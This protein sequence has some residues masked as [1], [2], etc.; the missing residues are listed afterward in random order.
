MHPLRA[1]IAELEQE[2]EAKSAER[3][4]ALI[5]AVV[6]D[7]MTYRAAGE[8]FGISAQRV[9]QLVKRYRASQA[10]VRDFTPAERASRA[11][12]EFENVKH[13]QDLRAERATGGATR[14][15]RA[16]YGS[17]HESQADE[18]EMRVG[19]RE[20]SALHSLGRVETESA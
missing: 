4:L 6:W 19:L 1:E 5:E 8:V 17:I 13:A 2:L 11:R 3:D 18:T 16:F 15:L 10:H 14:E 12:D 20:W 7:G 9:H